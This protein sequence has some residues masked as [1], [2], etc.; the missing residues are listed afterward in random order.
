M[1]NGLVGRLA[2][3]RVGTS[4]NAVRCDEKSGVTPWRCSQGFWQQV[5]MFLIKRE[6][7]R[8]QQQQQMIR[9]QNEDGYTQQ[10]MIR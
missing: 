2:H 6:G 8:T 10:Q 9:S 4:G 3:V 7:Y 5:T 1:T